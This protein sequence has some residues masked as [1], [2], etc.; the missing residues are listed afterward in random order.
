MCLHILFAQLL[1]KLKKLNVKMYNKH[2]GEFKILYWEMTLVMFLTF[3]WEVA[4]S[5]ILIHL[6]SF[7]VFISSSKQMIGYYLIWVHKHFFPYFS[8]LL[9]PIVCYFAIVITTII[10]KR[11][12]VYL[13]KYSTINCDQNKGN[14]SVVEPNL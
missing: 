4:S 8:N 12:S 1:N 5:N 14:E 10:V 2:N 13:N 11:I 9:L 6:V 3:I 7:M